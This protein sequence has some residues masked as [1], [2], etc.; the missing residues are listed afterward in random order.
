MIL[1]S[2]H[3]L[4]PDANQNGLYDLTTQTFRNVAGLYPSVH[5][6]TKDE[7]MRMDLVCKNL[8]N[9]TDYLDLLMDL[10]DI[11]NPLNVMQGD[12]VYYIPTSTFD[13]YKVYPQAISNVK[14]LISQNKANIKD[15]TR[16]NYIEN[17]Y[18]LAP[19]FLDTPK[20]PISYSNGKITIAP[21]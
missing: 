9:T 16:V 3:S 1:H 21:I 10:N 7:E 19:T 17:N 8:L 18:Q 4:I 2:I 12:L 5:T 6:V 13:I 15:N 14:I 20:S 11:D